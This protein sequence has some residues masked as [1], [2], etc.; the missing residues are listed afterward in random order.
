MR[1]AVKGVSKEH[2]YNIAHS[3]C[4]QYISIARR[5]VT[6]RKGLYMKLEY[7]RVGDYL[8]PNI[9]LSEPP[10]AEPLGR[11]GMLRKHYSKRNAQFCTT[12]F[13]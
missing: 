13:C 12:N 6:R 5:E 8:L 10:N 4:L 2:Y 9:I 3:T 11:Y 7:T 1:Y